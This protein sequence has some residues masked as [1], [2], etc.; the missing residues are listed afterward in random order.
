[1]DPTKATKDAVEYS[2][3]AYID[4]FQIKSNSGKF[5]LTEIFELF[6][7]IYA[8]LYKDKQPGDK[9]QRLV[10]I[11][12][13]HN[14]DLDPIEVAKDVTGLLTQ[15]V[16][17][18]KA[19]R[20]HLTQ[21]KFSASQASGSKNK[22][23][24]TVPTPAKKLVVPS[25][26]LSLLSPFRSTP[27]ETASD[28]PVQQPTPKEDE[29]VSPSSETSEASVATA[30]Q[31]QTM[32]TAQFNNLLAR[33][34]ALTTAIQGQQ[35]ANNGPR[36]SNIVKVQPFRGESDDPISWIE[37]FEAAANANGWSTARRLQ[38]VPAYLKDAAAQWLQGRKSDDDT[39]PTH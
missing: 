24:L 35:P 26:I 21:L 19:R 18:V 5:T 37:D 17:F 12:V 6:N 27:E 31:F 14:P 1:V 32:D 29:P 10:D 4:Y 8:G 11:A 36:E 16:G 13:Q 3:A 23:T 34:E 22:S 28:E 2:A 39:R 38:V 9:A 25:N 20:K 33:L 30:I 15:V 7:K